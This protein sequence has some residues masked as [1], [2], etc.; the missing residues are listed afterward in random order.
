MKYDIFIP[1][2]EGKTVDT[3]GS[4]GGQCMD[5]MHIFI[6]DVLGLSL[7][8]LAAPAAKDVYNNFANM[9]GA[10]NFEKIANTPTG[11]PQK[12]DIMFWGTGVG[13]YGHVAIFISG[14]IN[15]FVSFDQNWGGV[16]KCL[17]INHSYNSVMGWLRPKDQSNINN[18]QPPMDETETD[19]RVQFN[20]IVSFLLSKDYI[21]DG[22]SRKYAKPINP[23]GLL[24]VIQRLWTDYETQRSKAGKFDQLRDRAG[25]TGE[26]TIDAVF[27]KIK[28]MGTADTWPQKKQQII[29]LIN[30]L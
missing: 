28:S 5:L 13:Q 18:S 3:D 12:G 29:N 23:A 22:D 25:L 16:Q 10:T 4:F 26:Q 17:K 2:Y 9:N 6:Q 8:V 15:G 21:K 1:T 27:N 30:S 19:K 24:K 7:T 20:D 14:D 11:V